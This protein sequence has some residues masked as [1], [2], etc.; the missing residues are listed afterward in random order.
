M[1]E[2]V[3][4][5]AEH[6]DNDAASILLAIIPG[7]TLRSLPITLKNPVAKLSSDRENSSQETAVDHS[8]ELQ[9]TRQ[10]EFILHYAVLDA[11]FLCQTS[12]GKRGFPIGRGRFLTIYMLAGP[13]R[14]AEAFRSQGG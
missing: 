7:G 11:N 13:Q 4:P 10:K 6:I 14:P 1:R 12:Q 2:H 5:V 8:L 9:Q 3:L